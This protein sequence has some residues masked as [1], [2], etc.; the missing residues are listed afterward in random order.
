MQARSA[1]LKGCSLLEEKSRS[2]YPARLKQLVD[3]RYGSAELSKSCTSLL[4]R[5]PDSS[6]ISYA[7]SRKA[8]LASGANSDCSERVGQTPSPSNEGHRIDDQA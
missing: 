1:N 7:L 5:K 4:H 3:T 8:L 2:L 6:R